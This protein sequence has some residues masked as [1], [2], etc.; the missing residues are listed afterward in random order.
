MITPPIGIAAPR[1]GRTGPV[2][3]PRA[4]LASAAPRFR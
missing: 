1:G 2:G 3:K 4:A